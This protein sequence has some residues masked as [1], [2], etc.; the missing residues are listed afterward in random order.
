[1][2]DEPSSI[3]PFLF[4]PFIFEVV[5]LILCLCTNGILPLL[6]GIIVLDSTMEGRLWGNTP[7]ARSKHPMM[8]DC[9]IVKVVV[10]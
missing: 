9:L 10:L 3:S 5:C 6:E 7:I 8:N 4:K 1:M 2:E